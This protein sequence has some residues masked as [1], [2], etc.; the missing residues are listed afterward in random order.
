MTKT[1]IIK[2]MKE[3]GLSPTTWLKKPTI[4]RLITIKNKIEEPGLIRDCLYIDDV[5][6]L[7]LDALEKNETN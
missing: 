3:K 4:Q 7:A 5:I 6:N 1:Q 2:E